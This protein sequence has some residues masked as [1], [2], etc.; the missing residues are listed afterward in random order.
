MPPDVVSD[1]VLVASEGVVVGM[2]GSECLEI[3]SLVQTHLGWAVDKFRSISPQFTQATSGAACKSDGSGA[4]DRIEQDSYS[5]RWGVG[6]CIAE[7][8][9][10]RH[11]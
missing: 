8:A 3:V 11:P 6:S 1:T 9:A 7:P 2:S 4:M 10:G 5:T